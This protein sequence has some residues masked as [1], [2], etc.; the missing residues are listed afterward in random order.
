[1]VGGRAGA[2]PDPRFYVILYDPRPFRNG[3][4]GGSL[5]MTHGS[6]ENIYDHCFNMVCARAG[7]LNHNPQLYALFSLMHMSRSC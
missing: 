6:I 3:V 5:F 2:S 7:V 1:M 4:R